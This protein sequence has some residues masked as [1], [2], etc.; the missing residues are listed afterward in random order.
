MRTPLTDVRNTTPRHLRCWSGR[1]AGQHAPYDDTS[2]LQCKLLPVAGTLS[3]A[4]RCRAVPSPLNS[5]RCSQ[6]PHY[7]YNNYYN[8]SPILVSLSWVLY[9]SRAC[10]CRSNYRALR[11]SCTRQ[12]PEPLFLLCVEPAICGVHLCRNPVP[13]ASRYYSDR[14]NTLGGFLRLHDTVDYA[15]YHIVDFAN[16]HHNEDLLCR[17]LL[18]ASLKSREGRSTMSPAWQTRRRLLLRPH[19][20]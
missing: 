15:Y 10:Q 11:R 13:V 14:S 16:E 12:P 18:V 2:N 19:V 6:D 8:C 5:A 1:S 17:H 9:S 4:I 20:M 3:A 7:E